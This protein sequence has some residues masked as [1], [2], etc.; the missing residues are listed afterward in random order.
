MA[1]T[2][3]NLCRSA[4][5]TVTKKPLTRRSWSRWQTVRPTSVSDRI[6]AQVRT[7]LFRGELNPG[8]FLGS[9]TDLAQ[10][11]GVSRVPVRDAFR[12]LQ[13]MGIVEVRLGA[14]GGA[15]I[16]AGDPS[17]FADALAVQFKLVGMSAE[18][19]FEAQIAVEGHAAE[20][21]AVNATG[22]D[23][24]TLREML[25]H[26]ESVIHDADAFTEGGL[27]FH[28]AIVEAS[29]NRALIAFAR[30]LVEVLYESYAPQTTPALARRVLAKHAK[31]LTLIEARQGA[32]ARDAMTAHLRQVR[33][34]VLE[35]IQIARSKNVASGI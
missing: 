21:A 3:F 16:A 20:L 32:R 22:E 28:F 26:L 4:A 17:C 11:L 27:K 31:V 30:A 8:D 34:R 33:G 23:L 1:Q 9:E 6:V 10:K 12:T 25:G 2:T 18:E 5:S 24:A 14:N 19:L 35:N 13:A 29:H 7:A 15:H